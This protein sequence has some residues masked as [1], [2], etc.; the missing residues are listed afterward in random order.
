MDESANANAHLHTQKQVEHQ[1]SESVERKLN[2]TPEEPP[3]H[4]ETETQTSDAGA[5]ACRSA[6]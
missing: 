5:R 6:A 3:S 2:Y 4:D 1:D